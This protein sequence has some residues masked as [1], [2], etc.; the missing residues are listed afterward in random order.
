MQTPCAACETAEGAG[1]GDDDGVVVAEEG[2]V[3]GE[4]AGWRGC[5]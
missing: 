2:A 1:F 4:K 3:V 5:V